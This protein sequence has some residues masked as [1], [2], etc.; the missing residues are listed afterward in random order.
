M[1]WT[2][3]YAKQGMRLPFVRNRLN[4][5]VTANLTLARAVNRDLSYRTQPALVAAVASGL[6]TAEILANNDF[7]SRQQDNVRLTVTPSIGYQFSNAVTGTF[8]LKI[9]KFDT[10]VA[11]PPSYFNTSGIFNIR[12]NIASF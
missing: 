12:V 10:R 11:Q 2:L 3:N 1:Q 6:S 8:S 5:R 4:N 9:E 7:V